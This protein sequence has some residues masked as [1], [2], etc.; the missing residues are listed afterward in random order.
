M[1]KKYTIYQPI[2]ILQIIQA[3]YKQQQQYDPI[4]L[5]NEELNFDTTILELREICELVD[6]AELGKSLNYYFRFDLAWELWVKVLEPEY[7][8]TLGD[9]SNFI[10]TYAEKEIIEPI[11]LFGSNCETTAIFKSLTAKLNTK[12]ACFTDIQTVADLIRKIH[13]SHKEFQN[14]SAE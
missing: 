1:Y 10:A 4:V 14:K 9:L 2:E 5:I 3:N 6:I 7:E 12:Q 8:R 13:L 11:K